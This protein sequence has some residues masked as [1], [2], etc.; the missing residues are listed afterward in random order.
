MTDGNEDQLP[1]EDEAK[2]LLAL[3]DLLG[4]TGAGAFQ[5]RFCDEEQ[6][7]VWIACAKWGDVWQAAGGMSPFQA[8]LQLA[9][10]AMDGG[11]CTHCQKP[12]GVD[13]R[14]IDGFI[15]RATSELICWYRYDPELSTFRR[16]CEGVAA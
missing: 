5:I 13:D 12:T 1:N 3:V 11:T 14:P 7:I 10:S 15:T 16:S 6:P 4:R 2:V 8:V 9:E